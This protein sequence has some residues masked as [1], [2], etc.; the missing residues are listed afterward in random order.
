M[1]WIGLGIYSYAL[2]G[3]MPSGYLTLKI[4]FARELAQRDVIKRLQ[5]S[6]VTGI[7]FTFTCGVVAYGVSFFSPSIPLVS[8]FVYATSLGF[9]GLTI[10]A[11]IANGVSHRSEFASKVSSLNPITPSPL[12]STNPMPASSPLRNVSEPEPIPLPSRDDS[13]SFESNRSRPKKESSMLDSSTSIPTMKK[14]LFSEKKPVLQ[15]QE[16][17]LED[18]FAKLTQK[19]E[20]ALTATEIAQKNQA[21]SKPVASEPIRPPVQKQAAFGDSWQPVKP[22]FGS[23]AKPSTDMDRSQKELD[24]QEAELEKLKQELSRRFKSE[25]DKKGESA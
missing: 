14:S 24:E 23:T 2:I 21:V 8:A 12:P 5:W 3:A 6:A 17:S 20:L 4:L 7:G 16:K 13:L 11:A 1:D 9:L 15:S 18:E 10:A 19:V 25:D 22:S